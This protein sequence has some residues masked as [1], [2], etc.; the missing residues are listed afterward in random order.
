MKFKQL[1]LCL[2]FSTLI[3]CK[4]FNM[5]EY[6][7][8]IESS[9]SL[10]PPLLPIWDDQQFQILFP[11]TLVDDPYQVSPFPDGR[12]IDIQ[13][14]YTQMVNGGISHLA[15]NPAGYA[16]LDLNIRSERTGLSA[17]LSILNIG[18]LA[19][20]MALG[21]P[22]QQLNIECIAIVQVLDNNEKVL[23]SYMGSAQGKVLNT[24]YVQN[25][26]KGTMEVFAQAMENVQ[27]H[28]QSDFLRLE[29]LLL[30]EQKAF[31]KE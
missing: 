25:E 9:E 14:M 2:S 7:Q 10:L 18:L 17:A 4:P 1:L 5:V 3:A 30:T 29:R 6:I 11:R 31:R 12:A 20:P 28:I 23:G 27:R 19:I 13:M 21:V 15:G 8:S 24:L 22:N 16:V 26:R